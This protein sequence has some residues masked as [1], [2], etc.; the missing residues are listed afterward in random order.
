MYMEID[1]RLKHTI[2][3]FLFILITTIAIWL[4][5]TPTSN[6]QTIVTETHKQITS[7]KLI[8]SSK[9]KPVQT[10]HLGLTELNVVYLEL[11]GFSS[12][13][14]LFPS[15]F[16]HSHSIPIIVTGATSGNYENA[17]LLV[18]S[19]QK[20]LHNKTVVIF[21]LGL[22]SYELLKVIALSALF[23]ISM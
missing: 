13:S 3:L 1:M 19:V 2:I 23:F 6:I 22:G 17:I 20:H 7:L 12:L 21:D 9:S 18:E 4:V 16:E 5:S 8:K 15:N 10:H 14:R 11:L